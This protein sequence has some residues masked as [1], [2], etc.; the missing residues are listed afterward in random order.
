VHCAASTGLQ[1]RAAASEV[2]HSSCHV[3]LVCGRV[4]WVSCHNHLTRPSQHLQFPDDFEPGPWDQVAGLP[5]LDSD[6][7]EA[8][9]D[10]DGN[11]I[12]AACYLQDLS[13]ACSGPGVPCSFKFEDK[14][15]CMGLDSCSAHGDMLV[16]HRMCDDDDT[17]CV[18]STAFQ[19]SD[20]QRKNCTSQKSGGCGL[21]AAF[22]PSA[23]CC[24][25]F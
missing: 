25:L 3:G 9:V 15:L 19:L 2:K 7:N 8:A 18:S 23:T 21:T 4:P 1:G 6:T 16:P 11:K 10:E 22:A 5:L 13:D 17:C 12:L 24:L 20:V 14:E